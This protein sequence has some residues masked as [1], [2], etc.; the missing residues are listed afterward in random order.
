MYENR[1]RELFKGFVFLSFI[2]S[3][4]ITVNSPKFGDIF[5]I[6]LSFYLSVDHTFSFFIKSEKSN[7]VLAFVLLRKTSL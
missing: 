3:H 5:A 6:N 2:S 7:C 1:K 4:Y